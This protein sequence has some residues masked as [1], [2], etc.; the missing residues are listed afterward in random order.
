MIDPFE[1]GPPEVVAYGPGGGCVT[2]SGCRYR[3]PGAAAATVASAVATAAS[4][5]TMWISAG[6]QMPSTFAFEAA[7]SSSVRTPCAWRLARFCS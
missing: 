6:G 1:G 3:D 4:L 7:N 5:V 2:G